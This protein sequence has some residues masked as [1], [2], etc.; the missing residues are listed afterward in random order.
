YA[1]P[2]D[3]TAIANWSTLVEAGDIMRIGW[4][5]GGPH[6]F[7]ILAPLDQNDDITVFDNVYWANN[8]EAI[9]IHTAQ[10]WTQTNPN[11]ISI[12]RL[13]SNNLYLIDNITAND[14]SV[15]GTN[16]NDLIIPQ[17]T[18]D[19]MSGA[20]GDDLFADTSTILN[21]STITDFHEGDTIDFTDLDS[22]DTTV[23][24]D[25]TTGVLT[26]SPSG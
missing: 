6:S 10:Y 17:G 20:A 22:A 5:S 8:Y 1:A 26:L 24:Y 7:T 12:Y 14:A 9:G 3:G 19:I 4:T 2:Q 13:D 15:Q 11:D 25:A 18:A 21:G 16:Y 23:G